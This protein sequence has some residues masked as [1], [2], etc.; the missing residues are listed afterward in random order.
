MNLQLSPWSL[1][2]IYFLPLY[3]ILL[4]VSGETKVCRKSD[5]K[6]NIFTN[7][8]ELAA[9]FPNYLALFFFFLSSSQA[10]H[11]FHLPSFPKSAAWVSDRLPAH[12]RSHTK[13][14]HLCDLQ[15]NSTDS[16]N[17]DQ[18]THLKHT[19]EEEI[20]VSISNI[21]WDQILKLVHMSSICARHSLLHCEVLFRVHYTNA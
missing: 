4:L 20:G 7:Y 9:R 13:A 11:T 10:F 1:K 14:V 15:Y 21:Q 17:P 8:T 18:T 2:I 6:E 5:I 3:Q 12:P 16:L 19:W